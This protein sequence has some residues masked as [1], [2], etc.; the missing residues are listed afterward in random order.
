M[1]ESDS[2]R[3]V[4]A[5]IRIGSEQSAITRIGSRSIHHYWQLLARDFQGILLA[6]Q[7]RPDD[8]A[9]AWTWNET[10]GSK[11][12]TPQEL[13][14]LRDRLAAANRSFAKSLD[15]SDLGAERPGGSSDEE[16]V[17]RLTSKVN[18]M[19]TELARKPDPKFA[20]FACRTDGGLRIH[21]WGASNPA[22]PFYPDARDCEVSG[23]VLVGEKGAADFEVVIESRTGACLA[24]TRSD[25][26]G[27]FRLQKIGPGT[28]RVR[29]VSD[30]VDFPVSGMVVT[31]ERASIANLELRSTSLTVATGRG[32]EEGAPSSP[33]RVLPPPARAKE[34]PAPLNRP[35]RRRRRLLGPAIATAVLIAAGG[36]WWAWN[37]GN[38]GDRKAENPAGQPSLSGG[39]AGENG[40]G[41]EQVQSTRLADL[42]RRSPSAVAGA[43][44]LSPMSTREPPGSISQP[45][46]PVAK[47][48]Q[49][50]SP[51]PKESV[52]AAGRALNR[53]SAGSDHSVLN[54]KVDG[55]PDVKSDASQAR[56]DVVRPAGNA[57]A[58]IRDAPEEEAAD[59]AK[60]SLRRKPV[61]SARAAAANLPEA[62]GPAGT[63]SSSAPSVAGPAALD[64]KQGSISRRV[65]RTS[66]TGAKSGRISPEKGIPAG[67]L[68]PA[69]SDEPEDPAGADGSGGG[70]QVAAET[71]SRPAEAGAAA[72]GKSPSI[73][74]PPATAG[75]PRAAD[76]SPEQTN[77]SDPRA[78]A[79]GAS[80]APEMG[81]RQGNG[82]RVTPPKSSRTGSAPEAESDEAEQEAGDAAAVPSPDPQSEK[83]GAQPRA[84]AAAR[85]SPPAAAAAPIDARASGA[86]SVVEQ[87]SERPRPGTP[88]AASAEDTPAALPPHKADSVGNATA[89]AAAGGASSLTAGAP[90]GAAPPAE[91]ETSKGERL[92]QAVR[93]RVSGWRP[94]LVQDVIL[95]TQPVRD[96]EDDKIERLR[97]QYLKEQ[98][99]RIPASFRNPVLW[100]GCVVEASAADVAA[101][102]PLRWQEVTGPD[103]G[104]VAVSG[105]RAEIAWPAGT[106]GTG[107]Y[108]LCRGDGRA[109]ADISVDQ[110][111]IL[112]R[113]ADRTRCWYWVAVEPAEADAAGPDGG[114]AVSRFDWQLRQ[115][116]ALPEAC[117]RND[118]W[119]DGRARRLEIPVDLRVEAGSQRYPVILVDQ[120]TGW[121]IGRDIEQDP[122]SGAER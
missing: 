13:A 23:T 29:V 49:A 51:E 83:T 117:R 67:G 44:G 121:A 103:S 34:A 5:E 111:G 24:R 107:R 65:A 45:P 59:G 4:V 14:D 88:P 94:Q 77:G 43:R 100:N 73:A 98:Q 99:A 46:A 40:E 19:I 15:G 71:R 57:D 39:R 86:T 10:A 114:P 108:V 78:D 41:K 102:G 27:V 17:E 6:P 9:V 91:E 26:S 20:A 31:I 92:G 82:R 38:A 37:L 54:E 104:T 85:Q 81:Q 11:P 22:Q 110:S 12:V 66:T 36:G 50:N 116:A 75:S 47:P 18:E 2:P 90:L 55:A 109:I 48:R 7:R 56:E 105:A 63:D 84:T 89:D 32:S 95:P 1:S 93:I 120:V 21:S 80:L 42:G 118:R 72:G 30:R 8:S 58:A 113:A 35:P 68:L 16:S 53:P 74:S 60:S 76:E 3:R 70:P 101:A 122:V 106:L 79:S 33:A 61:K 115:G 97:G 87:P 28:H 112:I 119:R 96:G 52:S 25:A 62:V 69:A 64:A